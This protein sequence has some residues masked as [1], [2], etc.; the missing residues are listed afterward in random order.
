MRLAI[1]DVM[2]RRVKTLVDAHQELG[3]HHVAWDGRDSA[4]FPVASGVYFYRISWNGRSQT[5]RAMLLK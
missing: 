3:M 4:G 2:G 5:G 1:Y